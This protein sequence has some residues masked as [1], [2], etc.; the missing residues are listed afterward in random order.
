MIAAIMESGYWLNLEAVLFSV[1]LISGLIGLVLLVVRPI[2]KMLKDYNE[3]LS[4]LQ[5]AIAGQ[6]QIIT[7]QAQC[8]QDSIADREEIREDMIQIKAGLVTILKIELE[9]QCAKA[10]QVGEITIE[11]KQAI[12]EMFAEYQRLGGNHGMSSRVN[13]VICLPV[14]LNHKGD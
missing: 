8:I 2:R 10:L 12:E 4:H 14:V 13:S 11:R 1:T 9:K 7:D 6:N 3:T 5:T